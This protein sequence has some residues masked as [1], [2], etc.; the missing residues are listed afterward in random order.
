MTSLLATPSTRSADCQQTQLYSFY[1]Q[2][3]SA[4]FREKTRRANFV[5][6]CDS[7]PTVSEQASG[8][9]RISL[10]LQFTVRNKFLMT[11]FYLILFHFISFI[12]LNLLYLLDSTLTSPYVLSVNL[13]FHI[14]KV[15]TYREEEEEEE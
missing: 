12:Y 13:Y 3:S 5:S 8:S 2:Y 14:K 9:S 11:L 1:M 10:H 4:I 15:V 7:S 6:L